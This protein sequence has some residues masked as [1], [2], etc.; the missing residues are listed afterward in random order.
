ML[1]TFALNIDR[2]V[3]DGLT[4]QLAAVVVDALYVERVRDI[5][6]AEPEFVPEPLSYA[7]AAG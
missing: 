1:P 6:V 5:A 2:G 7:G 3:I 4:N